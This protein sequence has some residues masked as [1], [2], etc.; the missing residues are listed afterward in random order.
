[1]RDHSIERDA[2]PW[3]WL[4]IVLAAVLRLQGLDW[5]QGLLLHPDERNIATA[6]ARLAFPDKLIPE[7]HAYNGLSL[8]LPRLLAEALLPWNGRSEVDAVAIVLA[9]RMLSAV[10]SILALPVIWS[11]ARRLLGPLGGLVALI[12]MAASPGL[13]QAAH[14]AT[15]ESGLIFCLVTLIWLSARHGTG[16]LQLI[17]FTGLS[18]LVLGLGFGL[19]TTALV[20]AIVPLVTAIATTVMRGRI[21]AALTAGISA[22]LIVGLI[23]CVTTPQ[24]WAAPSAYLDTLRFESAVVSGAADVF[25]TYQ[26]T[27][28]SNGVFELSQLPWLVGP[29]VAP[30]G[31]AGLAIFLWT[32]ARGNRPPAGLAATAAFAV[33]YA[34]IIFGWHAKFIRYSILLIPPLALFAGYFVT[35]L[36]SRRLRLGLA[37]AIVLATGVAGLAQAAIYQKSDS[38]IAAWRWLVPQLRSGDR[39]VVEPVDLAPPFAAPLAPHI[40]TAVLPLIDLPSPQKLQ[41][42]AEILSA[43]QWMFIA[44]RRHYGVLPRLK[45]RFPELCG[46]YDALWSGRLGYRVVAKFRRRPA[47]PVLIDPEVQAEE[48]FTVFDSPTTIILANDSHLSAERIK[49]QLLAAPAYCRE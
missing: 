9:G 2:V 46:Y 11:A 24:I 19:K 3:A 23:A 35:Q 17:E 43:S 1:M 38:R 49:T 22:L 18:G 31:L 37:A 32:L 33:V 8:Y 13:I 41:Q 34:A 15:T 12:A 44:S 20:F 28:A 47:W 7:F 45:R 21:V 14:F 25:W 29:L 30:V 6:A 48:T 10:F 16:E 39:L 4:V 42:M 27:G 5:D 40:D 36:V 26:F